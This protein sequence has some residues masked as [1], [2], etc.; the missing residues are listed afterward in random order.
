MLGFYFFF[1]KQQQQ[2]NV[3][4]PPPPA[5]PSP[6][7]FFPP[8]YFCYLFHF[9]RYLCLL[10]YT[11][12]HSDTGYVT[13]LCFLQMTRPQFQRNGG[14][15]LYIIYFF[16][17]QSRNP[18][19]SMKVYKVF[20]LNHLYVPSSSLHTH[21]HHEK[22]ALEL[23]MGPLI[24]VNMVRSLPVLK[25]SLNSRRSINIFRRISTILE[26]HCTQSLRAFIHTGLMKT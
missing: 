10:Q 1:F 9:M 21:S 25:I 14:K 11:H 15:Y 18:L 8:I 2:V 7:L 23:G 6:L 26:V 16:I 19:N 5:G 3:A 20:P 12:R 24:Y 4:P 17:V 22:V 13:L